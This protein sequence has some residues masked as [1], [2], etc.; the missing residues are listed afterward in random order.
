MSAL[1]ALDAMVP[2]MILR[3]REWP[4]DKLRATYQ[5]GLELSRNGGP[6]ATLWE[7]TMVAVATVLRERA[8]AEAKVTA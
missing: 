4:T 8:A 2:A 7:E 6:T 1:A 3:A 5:E